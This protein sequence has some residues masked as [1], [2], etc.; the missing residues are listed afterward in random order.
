MDEM[1]D[2][3]SDDFMEEKETEFKFFGTAREVMTRYARCGLCGAN[4]HFS[5]VTDF[6]KNMTHETARCPECAIKPR[7]L[8]HRLH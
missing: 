6:T 1:N 8:M 7:L 2:G 3:F 4:L 5:H